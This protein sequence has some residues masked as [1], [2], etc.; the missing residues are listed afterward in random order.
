MPRSGP[1]RTALAVKVNVDAL[2]EIDRLAAGQGISR[3][4]W[5]RAAIC[6]ALIAGQRGKQP[7]AIIAP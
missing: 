3:S 1:R 5:V 4:A 6:D 2:T 7:A